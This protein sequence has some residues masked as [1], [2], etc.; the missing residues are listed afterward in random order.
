M[1]TTQT[2]CKVIATT[3]KHSTFGDAGGWQK[4]LCYSALYYTEVCPQCWWLRRQS[5][6]THVFVKRQLNDETKKLQTINCHSWLHGMLTNIYLYSSRRETKDI[7]STTLG[8]LLNTSATAVT[9]PFLF[10][11]KKRTRW[12]LLVSFLETRQWVQRRQLAFPHFSISKYLSSSNEKKRW[13]E[14]VTNYT[15]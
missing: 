6:F 4:T 12:S 10:W 3:E 7:L 11:V 1:V 8:I 14:I 9:S 15:F 2:D 5:T 13:V